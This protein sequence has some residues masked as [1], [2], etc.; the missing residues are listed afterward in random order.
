MV[1]A[2]CFFLLDNLR[3]KDYPYYPMAS[4]TEN[5]PH[6]LDRF[7]EAQATTFDRALTELKR[8]RKETHWM[9]FIFPQVAGL[10]SSRMAQRYAITSPSEAV[11]YLEHPLLGA[12]L[13]EITNA[14]L[15]HARK[16]AHE[17]LDSPD[18]QKFQSCMTLFE[19]AGGGLLFADA[20]D[21]FY[22]GERDEKTIAIYKLWLG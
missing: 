4:G 2:R 19:Q 16:T 13:T 18:D 14:I 1:P 3:S 8:G 11:A 12:R 6:N 7:V 21:R 9:W 22:Q 20:L 5:D 15:Q 17:I 10:G